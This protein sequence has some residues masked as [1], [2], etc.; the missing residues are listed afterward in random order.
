[1]HVNS[2]KAYKLNLQTIMI[3]DDDNDDQLLLS[4]AI[5]EIAPHIQLMPVKD[6]NELLS[7]LQVSK[8]DLLFLDL[9]MPCKSGMECLENIRSNEG[10]AQMPVVVFSSSSRPAN[11]EAAYNAGADLFFT[12]PTSYRE[13]VENV[14]VILY[15]NWADP[16]AIQAIKH[17]KPVFCAATGNT[18]NNP[19]S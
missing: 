6:G 16:A 10:H 14:K 11:V 1:M 8:P 17:S 3:A 15:L 4:Q 19:Q 2:V 12:K 7:Q 13:L 9:Q 5:S 18:V